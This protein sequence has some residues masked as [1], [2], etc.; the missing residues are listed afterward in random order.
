MF[1]TSQNIPELQ[2]LIQDPQHGGITKIKGANA[3]L[4]VVLFLAVTHRTLSQAGNKHGANDIACLRLPGLSRAIKCL[5]ESSPTPSAS[6][7][8]APAL[9]LYRIASKADLLSQSWQLFRD[10]FRRSGEGGRN[11]KMYTSVSSI[12]GEMGDNVVWHAF[13]SEH[14]PCPALAAFHVSNGM[15][16]FC[17]TDSGQG[18]LKSLRRAKKWHKLQSESEALDAVV[19]K[20]ATSREDETE[21]GGFKLLFSNMLDYNGIV[22]LR[23]GNSNIRMGNNSNL[24]DGRTSRALHSTHIPGSSVTAV[25]AQAGHPAE[26]PVEK[27]S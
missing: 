15:A 14:K 23:S 2:R 6:P 27:N 20:R 18:F 11:S 24:G 8:G 1:L 17:V 5:S 10:R 7:F 9:D 12:I 3:S 26:I 19:T 22:V 13:E 4:S 21:G 25:F 16:S